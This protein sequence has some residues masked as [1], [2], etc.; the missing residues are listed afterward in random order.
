M[1]LAGPKICKKICI[2]PVNQGLFH[3]KKNEKDGEGQNLET[4]FFVY[5][6]PNSFHITA[7]YSFPHISA[8]CPKNNLNIRF[9]TEPVTVG[10][11]VTV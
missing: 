8:H 5:G 1:I 7:A 2:L 9:K 6:G 10:A 11:D 4:D 3:K